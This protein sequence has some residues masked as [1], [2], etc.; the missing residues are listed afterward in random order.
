MCN[1][2]VALGMC[3]LF[4]FLVIH[5][6]S[7]LEVAAIS[8][9]KRAKTVWEVLSKSMASSGRFGHQVASQCLRNYFYLLVHTA[10]NC[11]T[12]IDP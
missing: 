12:G 3:G 5:I 1:S 9:R 4:I 7:E 6:G 10:G 2:I 11:P 8:I